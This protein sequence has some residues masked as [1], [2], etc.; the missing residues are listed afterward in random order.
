MPFVYIQTRAG[1]SNALLYGSSSICFDC[2]TFYIHTVPSLCVRERAVSVYFAISYWNRL[3]SWETVGSQETVRVLQPRQ[4]ENILVCSY[5]QWRAPRA[6]SSNTQKQCGTAMAAMAAAVC[7]NIAWK[8]R[9]K[10]RLHTEWWLFCNSGQS[11]NHFA[12]TQ[13]GC[14]VHMPPATTLWLRMFG[15]CLRNSIHSPIYTPTKFVSNISF[16]CFPFFINYIFGT[17]AHTHTRT[18]TPTVQRRC[19]R[20]CLFWENVANGRVFAALFVIFFLLLFVRLENLW[21]S[22]NRPD[23]VWV[24]ENAPLLLIVRNSRV[25]AA[26]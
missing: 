4:Y 11:Q 21:T 15:V 17:L 12:S 6:A 9:E 14:R 25:I 7:T 16:V 19:F 23:F 20:L 3:Y 24:L 1:I 13:H 2:T 18:H 26:E 22:R 10:E 5:T 8:S